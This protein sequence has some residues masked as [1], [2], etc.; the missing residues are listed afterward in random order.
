VGREEKEK[1]ENVNKIK[2]RHM[3]SKNVV[4][5]TSERTGNVIMQTY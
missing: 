4:C 5:I 3:T 2:N 1:K